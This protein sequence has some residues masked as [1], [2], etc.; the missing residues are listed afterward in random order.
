MPMAIENIILRYIRLVVLV[1]VPILCVVFVFNYLL[2]LPA[3]I[4]NVFVGVP[5]SIRRL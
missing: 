1:G 4:V 5:R 3:T 2:G